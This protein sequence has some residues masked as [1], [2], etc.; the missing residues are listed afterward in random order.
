MAANITKLAR[1]DSL[2]D[3]G[4]VYVELAE[5]ITAKVSPGGIC[6]IVVT[7]NP[8][9][10]L[11]ERLAR[12]AVQVNQVLI[13][14]NA[15]SADA[16]LHVKESATIPNVI[17]KYNKTNLGIAAAMNIGVKYA[18]QV[19]YEWV[20]T[21]DQDSTVTP[22]MIASMLRAY[23]AF[24]EKEKLAL[25]SPR[26]CARTTGLFTTFAKG[27]ERVVNRLYAPVLRTMTSG[28]LIRVEIFSSVGYFNEAMFIDYVDN[29]FCLRC[30]KNGLNIIE[31]QE[32]VLIHSL[33]HITQ[34]KLLWH[35][36]EVTNHNYVRRYYITRNRMYI[37]RKYLTIFHRWILIDLRAFGLETIKLILFEHDRRRK[38]ISIFLG[39]YHGVIGKMGR[40][41]IS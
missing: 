22:G 35:K 17:V 3:N 34:H 24:P 18:V 20:M 29:E 4:R 2:C 15:S 21:F 10:G 30:V 41:Q 9:I 37:Y 25:V 7:Y 28:N 6:A 14:D 8:D 26:Y 40:K 38:M 33:G 11:P 31:A 36:C 13:V 5:M 16:I 19:G 27:P 23:D 1:A 32:A 39:I 12:T